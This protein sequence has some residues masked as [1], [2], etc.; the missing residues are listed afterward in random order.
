MNY[1]RK[2]DITDLCAT[3]GLSI[4][5]ISKE[6]KDMQSGDVLLVFSDEISNLD[7][8]SMKYNVSAFCRQSGDEL[9]SWETSEQEDALTFYIKKR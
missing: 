4:A 5:K 6:L 7:K 8:V 1:N 3:C 9:L 2:V